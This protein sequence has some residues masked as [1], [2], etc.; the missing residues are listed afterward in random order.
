MRDNATIYKGWY[1]VEQNIGYDF[2]GNGRWSARHGIKTLVTSGSTITTEQ[3]DLWRLENAPTGYADVAKFYNERL[4]IGSKQLVANMYD[5]FFNGNSLGNTGFYV[6]WF[7]HTNYDLRLA[8][9]KV[10]TFSIGSAPTIQARLERL[11]ALDSAVAMSDIVPADGFTT[12]DDTVNTWNKGY[13]A[14]CAG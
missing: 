5:N 10:Y 4:S 1:D 12:P 2:Y 8:N 11:R 7:L 9:L 13:I 3:I 14:S 6:N